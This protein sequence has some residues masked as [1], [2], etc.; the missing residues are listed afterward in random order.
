MCDASFC[1]LRATMLHRAWL[2]P[3]LI[4]MILVLCFI[5]DFVLNVWCNVDKRFNIMIILI[6][7]YAIRAYSVE[8]FGK[9]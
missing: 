9:L 4:Q 6:G 5:A 7:V 1:L 3:G 2:L 8:N